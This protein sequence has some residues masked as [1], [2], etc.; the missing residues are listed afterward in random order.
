MSLRRDVND[1]YREFGGAFGPLFKLSACAILMLFLVG[2]VIGVLGYGVSWLGE[3]GSVVREEAG[4]R[5]LLKKYEWFKDTSARLTALNAD[6]KAYDA[7]IAEFDGLK[8]SQMDRED[9][10]EISQ[11]KAERIGMIATYNSLSAEY[12][13]AMSKVNYRFTNVGEL[14][15]GASEVLPRGYPE[16]KTK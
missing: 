12:N 3:A 9:K 15:S 2:S 13:A 16:Y 14:P 4:P 11:L 6:I 7:R 10:Q 8:R 1:A 5:A